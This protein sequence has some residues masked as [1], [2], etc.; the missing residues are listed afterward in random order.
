MYPY[1]APTQLSEA[2]SNPDILFCSTIEH[3]C[4]RNINLLLILIR[5]KRKFRILHTLEVFFGRSYIFLYKF[6]VY[7][8]TDKHTRKD[9]G[10]KKTAKKSLRSL[11]T[12]WAETKEV[13]SGDCFL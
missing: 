4:T 7:Q 9:Q 5:I 12:K 2:K 3:D 10:A 6:T 11:Q 13:K 8:H 1:L